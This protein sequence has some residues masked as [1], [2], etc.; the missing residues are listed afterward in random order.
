MFSY[1]CHRRYSQTWGRK[2]PICYQKVT[3][4]TIESNQVDAGYSTLNARRTMIRKAKAKT[5]Q[6]RKRSRRWAITDNWSRGGRQIRLELRRVFC[7]RSRTTKGEVL[8]DYRQ[9]RAK[10][11]AITENKGQ[12]GE[13]SRTVETEMG[14]D[15]DRFQASNHRRPKQK[16]QEISKEEIRGG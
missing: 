15:N 1:H 5:D 14:N 9:Q 13:Q 7:K 8:R 2:S 16:W 12:S 11:R 10:R 6:D 3:A 4:I